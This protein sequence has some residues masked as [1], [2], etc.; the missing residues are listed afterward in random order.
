MIKKIKSVIINSIK[1]R[2]I[3]IFFLF[4]LLAFVILF[5]T[6]LSKEYTNT[7]AFKIDKIN[8]P[9]ENVVISDSNSMVFLTLKTHGFKWLHYY[10]AKP[11]ITIDFSKDVKKI[12]SAF[13]WSKDKAF[14]LESKQFGNQVQLLHIA[15]DTLFFKYDV[16]LV[17]KVPVILDANIKF[18]PGF[19][20]L[21]DFELVPDSIE[22][23]GP[24]AI[25]SQVKSIKT[26][27]IVLENIK[28]NLSKEVSLNLPKERNDIKF[29]NTSVVLNARVEK[30]TEG[31]LK[32]PLT[33]KN[34]P[35]GVK[36]KY[37]PKEV[38][39]SFYTSLSN[40]N[41]IKEKDFMVECDYSKLNNDQNYLIPELIKAPQAV[42]RA[43]INQ[44]RIEFIIAE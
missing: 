25:A 37:F 32:I 43:K 4:L 15:P 6:K 24:K 18:S 30:F 20:V 19:D 5:L 13:I 35:E 2:K 9:K 33:I 28:S 26:N 11:K 12:D 27:P 39:V 36:L 10:F 8:I 16:N 41:T 23:I 34:I 3:N 38:G 22:V 42:K 40:F 1:N 7:L 14:L 44:Q 31:T 17:K 29:S 21:K